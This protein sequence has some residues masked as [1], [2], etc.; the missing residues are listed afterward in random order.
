[1]WKT[2]VIETEHN[3]ITALVHWKSYFMANICTSPTNS[4]I[5]RNATLN[6]LWQ[7]QWQWQWQWKQIYC[8]SCTTNSP[9]K[10][11]I[12]YSYQNRQSIREFSEICSLSRKPYTSLRIRSSNPSRCLGSLLPTWI[13]NYIQYNVWGES[14]Y[15]FPNFK[16]GTVEVWEWMSNLIPHF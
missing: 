7:F 9:S 3:L 11:N 10:C 12:W 16:F 13:S 8:Q 15:P 6:C 14:T 5:L 4:T 1:M 2:N